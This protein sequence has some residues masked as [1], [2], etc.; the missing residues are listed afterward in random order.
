VVPAA[1]KW[2]DR[3]PGIHFAED[4]VTGLDLGGH[5][6]GELQVVPVVGRVRHRG[7]GRHAAGLAA[8]VRQVVVEHLAVAGFVA[9]GDLRGVVDA[10]HRRPRLGV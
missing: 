2:Q 5:E 3:G 4:R 9:G 10:D 1:G 8:A 7:E 6:V